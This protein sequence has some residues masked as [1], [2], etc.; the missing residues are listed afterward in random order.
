MMNKLQRLART[1]AYEAQQEIKEALQNLRD[2]GVNPLDHPAL[3]ALAEGEN[4]EHDADPESPVR[5]FSEQHGL[6]AWP[7]N[8]GR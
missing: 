8:G 5:L 6:D 7:Q 3:W 1:K 2:V 4:P